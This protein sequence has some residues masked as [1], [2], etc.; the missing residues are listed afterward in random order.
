[1]RLPTRIVLQAPAEPVIFVDGS[2]GTSLPGGLQLSHWPGHATP[3]ALRHDLSTGCALTFAH[4]EPT[5]CRRLAGEATAIV[6]NHYD[7]DGCLAMFAV[8][9]PERALPLAERMLATARAGD[10][11]RAPDDDALVLDALVMGL[12]DPERSPLRDELQGADDVT[13]WQR[14]I[15]HLMEAFPAL[16]E[17]DVAP[18]RDLWEPELARYRRDRE[19]L[20][21]A[22]REDVRKL[23]LSV[24]RA[25]TVDFAPGRHALFGSSNCDRAL[26]IAPI[27]DGA[28]VRLVVSSSSWFDLVSETRLPRP[29]LLPLAARLNAL[30]GTTETD[31]HAWRAQPLRNASPEL[32]FGRA[33]LDSF[34]EHN[35]ALAPT[36]LAPKLVRDEIANALM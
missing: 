17:G 36:R 32:W 9:H 23:D 22:E 6:N 34:A 7:T 29:D 1:V 25:R 4:L 18:Y 20:E 21:R 28:L 30:E 26:A 15:D 35:D 33:A 31:E 8:R 3:R 16:L 5:G 11:Y 27:H 24:W 12:S 19:A 14:C 2:P 10:L 13:R